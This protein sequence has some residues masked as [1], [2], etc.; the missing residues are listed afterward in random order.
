MTNGH[1]YKT[2]ELTGTSTTSQEDAIAQAIDRASQTLRHLR[3]FQVVDS[4][5]RIERG[6]VAQWQV[7]LKVGMTLEEDLLERD[8]PEELSIAGGTPTPNL[9]G[10]AALGR[11]GRKRS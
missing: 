10:R 4:R 1:V 6:Q 5:G 11:K 2:I 7:T 9:R 3:W 8:V